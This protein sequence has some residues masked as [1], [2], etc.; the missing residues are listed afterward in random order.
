MRRKKNHNYFF[1]HEGIIGHVSFA[2]KPSN[3]LENALL[4]MIQLAYKN[5][6]KITPMTQKTPLQETIE[7]WTQR[8]NEA[9]TLQVQAICKLFLEYLN[10][11][12]DKE[13]EF[14]GKV[15]DA[16]I[17]HQKADGWKQMEENKLPDNK[18]QFIDKLYPKS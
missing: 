3:K 7:Y 16:A 1:N 18:Q 11:Q 4:K 13:K 5:L 10:V 6:D 14:T 15:W 12:L 9:P 8:L 17:K 2:G